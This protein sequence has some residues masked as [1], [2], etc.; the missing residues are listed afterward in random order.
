MR[1]DDC[2]RRI[3]RYLNSDDCSPRFVNVQNKDDLS[4]ITQRFNVGNNDFLLVSSYAE[5]DENPKLDDIERE[6][7]IRSG[8]LFITGLSSYLKLLGEVVLTKEL[9][10]IA[11]QT[12]NAHVIMLCYQCERFLHFDDIRAARLVYNVEGS[13]TCVPD[14]VF[15]LPEL[16]TAVTATSVFGVE[17]IPEVIETMCG[18][19]LYVRTKKHKS[20]YPDA[21]YYIKEESR[22]FDAL[23]NI[24]PATNGL[25]S[26]FGS[27][28]QW[29]YALQEVV[30]YGS[31]GILITEQ[32]NV[33]TNLSLIAGNWKKFTPNKK[34][35][36]FIALKLNGAGANWCLNK[37]IE[38]ANSETKL[39]RQVYRSIL[40]VAHTDLAFWDKYNERKL[41]IDSFGG[42]DEEVIDYLQMLKSKEAEGLYYLTDGSKMEKERIFEL[43]DS[44]ASQFT[45]DEILEILSHTY[46]DLYDYLQ[47][48]RFKNEM[49][50]QYFQ[51]YKYQKVINKIYPEFLSVVDEQAIRRDYNSWLSPRSEKIESLNKEGAR[52][53]FVDALGVEYLS[54]ILARCKD[55]N[56]MADVSLCR[57]ELPSI[58]KINKEFVQAFTN[59]APDIKRLD[60]IKH[61]GEE[62]F[63]Y[64]QT[65]LP[66]H[67][68][69]ELEIVDGVLNDVRNRLANGSIERAYII[70]DHGS[71][72]LTVIHES[73]NQWEMAS[74]GEHSGRCCPISETD[75]QSEYVTEANGFWVLAS[76]DRF[77]GGRKASVEVHGG[78]TLEEVAVP[79]IELTYISGEIEVSINSKLPIEISFRKKA[80]L[81]L[82]SKTKLGGVTVCV[83]GKRVENKYYDGEPQSDNLYLIRMPDIKYAGDYTMTVFS[84]NNQ[85]AELDFSVK[86]EGS[87]ERSIL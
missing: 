13:N 15:I 72:R 20:N 25:E 29:A 19:K 37:A 81:Q 74:K 11:S 5:E 24:D 34:W 47:P 53:Y 8:N 86:K 4:A 45:R 61:H 41:L 16:A 14:I 60:D 63:D 70:S 17:H 71:S 3:E 80:E 9:Q 66:V 64:Q 26:Q 75:V 83:R 39:L 69:R 49:M 10:S 56:L 65:K 32:F 1:L 55:M 42:S 62:S 78:A 84:N 27:N 73:E 7:S 18:G 82:F 12:F 76:Y 46:H 50:Y 40:N 87:A 54:F 57:C 59:I 2:I 68:I 28:E 85:V 58:T 52:L 38:D 23:K 21:M 79:I 67:L 36:Y 31:W 33:P 35:L 77:K 51:D 30:K 44:Y 48:Y 22:A 6:L 43:L